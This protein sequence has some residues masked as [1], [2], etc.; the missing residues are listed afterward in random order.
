MG[1]CGLSL[2]VSLTALWMAV[3]R[4]ETSKPPR[5][6]A[7]SPKSVRQRQDEAVARREWEN[8]M[9]YDGNEQPPIDPDRVLGE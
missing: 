5:K 3:K 7:P 6:Q 8:F 2:L 4:R 9:S 1:L